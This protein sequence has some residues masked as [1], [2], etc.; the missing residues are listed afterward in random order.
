MQ[1]SWPKDLPCK[2][3]HWVRGPRRQA[4]AALVIVKLRSARIKN[5]VGIGLAGLVGHMVSHHFHEIVCGWSQ[6]AEGGT[7]EGDEVAMLNRGNA[8]AVTALFAT[9]K[10]LK[11]GRQLFLL[12]SGFMAVEDGNIDVG[13]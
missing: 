1:A 3:G 6:G 10:I 2:L 13:C 7:D 4:K 5:D 12:V 11:Y 8:L 9:F